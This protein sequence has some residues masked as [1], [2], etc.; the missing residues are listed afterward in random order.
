MGNFRL[1]LYSKNGHPYES[2]R[3]AAETLEAAFIQVTPEMVTN[4]NEWTVVR[5]V[6]SLIPSGYEWD[7]PECGHAN[8][9]PAIYSPVTCE[10]C[11]MEF[12]INPIV[13][14]AYD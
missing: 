6:A 9:I 4:C 10:K 8:T 14:H 3:L 7:C 12:E 5:D 13:N 1:I 2:K 11:G